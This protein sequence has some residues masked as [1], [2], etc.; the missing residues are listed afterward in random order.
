LPDLSG[1]DD[2][3]TA[4]LTV[5]LGIGRGLPPGDAQHLVTTFIRTTEGALRRYEDARLQLERSANE[6]SFMEY[7]RGLDDMEL[8]FMAL[9]RAMRLA[10]ALKNSCETNVGKRTL[11]REAERDQLRAMRNAIDHNVGPIVAHHAGKGHTLALLVREGDVT[12]DAIEPDAE[13]VTSLTVAHADLGRWL[14]QLH[15]L[16][17]D[18]INHPERWT[19]S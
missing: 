12:I 1:L 2:K 16:A 9:H 11:P 19:R 14:R 5:S 15:E 6:D 3:L 13:T 17:L 18:L 4:N 8:T 10:V 7:L